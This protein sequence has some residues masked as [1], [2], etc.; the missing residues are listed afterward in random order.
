MKKKA[1]AE[2]GFISREKVLPDTC[3]EVAHRCSGVIE[4]LVC[5]VRRRSWQQC[6]VLMRIL[7]SMAFWFNYHSLLTSASRKFLAES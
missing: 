1:A 3:T 5:C 6:L 2:V 7:R 4:G